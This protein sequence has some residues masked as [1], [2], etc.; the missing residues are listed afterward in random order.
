MSAYTTARARFAAWAALD[1][2]HLPADPVDAMQLRLAR[3]EV[4]QPFWRADAA[5]VALGC[6]EEV[7]ERASAESPDE[8]EDA[9]GDVAIYA[10]QV[11]MRN[12]L[13][14]SGLFD[15]ADELPALHADAWRNLCDAQGRV[16]HLAL[17]RSQRIREGALPDEEYR[18]RMATTIAALLGAVE[19]TSYRSGRSAR[20]CY[21]ITG[22]RILARDWTANRVTGVA[23]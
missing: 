6:C 3:W 9:M 12:R 15:A 10:G 1:S 5:F 18:A 16:A 11:A 17:K 2:P 22:A 8:I 20:D 23:P 13:A 21:L 7:G 4:R 14:M 19:A